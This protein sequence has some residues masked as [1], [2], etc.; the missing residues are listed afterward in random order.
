MLSRHPPQSPS[1]RRPVPGHWLMTDARLGDRLPQ[2]VAAMPPRSAIVVRPYALRPDNR[3]TLIRSIV[4]VARAKRHLLLLAGR[5]A[6]TGYDGRHGA[7]IP[8]SPAKPR[9]DFLSLAVHDR[10]EL[11]RA[12][13]WR[14]DAILVSP[15]WPTRTHPGAPVLGVRGFA[16]LA[17]SMPRQAVALGGMDKGRFQALR[18]HGA[19]GWAAIDAWLP[20]SRNRS[21]R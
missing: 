17:A 15:V 21:K 10:A 8:T 11:A 16:L 12:K 14:A 7:A 4:R 6:S 5:G 19:A 9:R 18:R 13:R 1:R 20:G 3:A 2:I